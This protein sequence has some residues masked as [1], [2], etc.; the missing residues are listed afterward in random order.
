MWMRCSVRI[1][2]RMFQTLQKWCISPQAPVISTA[3]HRMHQTNVSLCEPYFRMDWTSE[4]LTFWTKDTSDGAR[5]LVLSYIFWAITGVSLVWCDVL[6][7]RL[8]TSDQ[9]C[10]S[11]LLTDSIFLSIFFWFIWQNPLPHHL[12]KRVL[13]KRSWFTEALPSLHILLFII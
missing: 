1:V 5:E 10:L 4:N 7:M 11:S 6:F 12:I 8:T 9:K 3:W 13:S 2:R